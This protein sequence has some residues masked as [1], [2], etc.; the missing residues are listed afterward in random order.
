MW[1]ENKGESMHILE[2]MTLEKLIIMS[3]WQ[4]RVGIVLIVDFERRQ[5]TNHARWSDWTKVNFK[6]T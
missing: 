3:R 4:R 5:I 2:T 1:G 6:I